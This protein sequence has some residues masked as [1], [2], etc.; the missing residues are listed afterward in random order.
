MVKI[1]KLR[2]KLMHKLLY[3][4]SGTEQRKAGQQQ[5][6]NQ[7]SGLSLQKRTVG[8][9]AV[10]SVNFWGHLPMR[11]AIQ[12]FIQRVGNLGFPIPKLKFPT[13]S[14]ADFC[15]ILVLFSHPKEPPQKWLVCMKHCYTL[16]QSCWYHTGAALLDEYHSIT[17]HMLAYR[18]KLILTCILFLLSFD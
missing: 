6:L 14:F 4:K 10:V 17:E 9:Y 8:E 7:K 16:R 3:K 1:T 5:I 12:C 2:G 13:S 11:R 18:T 15:H